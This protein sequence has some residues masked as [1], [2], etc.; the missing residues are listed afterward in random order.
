MRIIEVI[1][2]PT[3]ESTV[4]TKGF[5]GSSCMQASKFIEEALGVVARDLKTPEFYGIAENPH[6]QVHQ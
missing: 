3:G 2:S 4:K 1:V 5:A 6:Q